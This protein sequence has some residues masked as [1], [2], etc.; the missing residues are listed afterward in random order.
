[1]A[2]ALTRYTPVTGMGITR[3]PDLFSRLFDESFV[4]PSVFD[5]SFRQALGSN[6][7]E[8]ND[9]YIVQVSLPGI[10]PDQVD[11]QVTGQQLVLKGTYSL[12]VPENASV[13]WN[14]ITGG[15][16]VESMTLPGEVDAATA[17]A[18][19]Q[20]GILTV[21]L[22]KAEHTKSRSIKVSVTK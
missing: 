21:T 2:T 15:D 6:L 10:N 13:I 11:L 22:P 1:M 4:M 14:G 12:P 9:D 5:R 16:F 18:T 8:S 3:L 19:Y 7:Y 20:K 17:N